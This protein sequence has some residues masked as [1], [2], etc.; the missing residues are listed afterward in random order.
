MEKI[1]M[2]V[3]GLTCA[4]CVP[5]IEGI[6]REQEGV[7]WATVNFAAGKA[8]VVYDPPDFNLARFIRS[9]RRL[10]FTLVTEREQTAPTLLGS[11]FMPWLH[12][13]AGWRRASHS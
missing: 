10:G 5:K 4:S 12:H 11:V 8:T 2:S 7:I 6:M 9:V 1:N 13:I 3:L